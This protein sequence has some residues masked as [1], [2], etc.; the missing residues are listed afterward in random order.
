MVNDLSWRV[1]CDR[2]GSQVVHIAP[3]SWRY[4]TW[5]G[6]VPKA[7]GWIPQGASR[8]AVPS[9]TPPSGPVSV[10][11][12]LA[13]PSEGY[14]ELRAEAPVG[15]VWQNL[16]P[17]RFAAATGLDVLPAVVEATDTPALDDGFVRDWPAPD[18]GVETHRIYRVQWY[19]FALL[20]AGL[21]IWF[22]RP[23]ATRGEDG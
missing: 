20:A 12:R 1:T 7:W 8:S 19:A 23:R 14:L 13:L 10:R 3:C 6:W 15:S 21:W 5:P 11:G 4:I 17:K 2:A 16:D 18:F 22:N 9:P